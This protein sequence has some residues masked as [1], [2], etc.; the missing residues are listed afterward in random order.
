MGQP[1]LC[2]DEVSFAIHLEILAKMRC[3]VAV[4]E[5]SRKVGNL[6]ALA[7]PLGFNKESPMVDDISCSMTLSIFWTIYQKY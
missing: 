1:P 7:T 3:A 4:R 6:Q 2:Q 5:N